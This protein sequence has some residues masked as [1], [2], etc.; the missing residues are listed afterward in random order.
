MTEEDWQARATAAAISAARKMITDKVV[1]PG[2]PI[3]R[4]SD[5]EFGWFVAAILFGWISTRAEQATAEG[6]AIEQAVR[7]TGLDS[8]PW[9]AGTITH[10]LPEL[11][12]TAGVDWS[13]PLKDWPR[14]TM[15]DFL[16]KALTLIRKALI[17]RDLGGG[18]TRKSGPGSIAR[19]ANAA[20]GGPLLAPDEL[21]D[22][23][24]F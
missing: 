20:A 12:D 22:E 7:L 3:G 4:L 2:T 5:T 19:Q 8:N 16:V 15:I 11:A 23:I 17:G 18:I 21:N 24:P 14:E 6:M 13:L 10:I 1:P 9:D